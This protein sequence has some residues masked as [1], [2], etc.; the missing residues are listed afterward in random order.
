ML[1]CEGAAGLLESAS[2]IGSRTP[3]RIMAPQYRPGCLDLT[4]AYP[5]A[6]WGSACLRRFAQPVVGTVEIHKA[7]VRTAL[8]NGLDLAV[9]NTVGAHLMDLHDAAVEIYQRLQHHRRTAF[10]RGPRRSGKALVHAQGA[11]GE[12]AGQMLMICAQGIHAQCAIALEMLIGVRGTVHA[13]Q[14]RGW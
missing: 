12:G 2:Q 3:Y 7:F 10:K 1:F 6:W 9:E 13:H 14:K 8:A 5:P 11:V 4:D